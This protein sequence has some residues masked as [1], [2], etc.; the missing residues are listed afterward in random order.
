[1]Q[2]R[3]LMSDDCRMWYGTHGIPDTPAITM[4]HGFTGSHA[5]WTKLEE[6]L[7]KDSFFLI[8]PDL[9]GHGRSANLIDPEIMTL[10][11]ISDDLHRLLDSRGIKKTAL[12]GYSMGGRAALYFALKY[13][14]RIDCLIL[15]SAS[16]GIQDPWERE[17]R[18]A[19]DAVLAA[20]I[21]KFGIPWFVEKWEGMQLFATQ[22]EMDPEVRESV[23]KER[24]SQSAR[25]LA[26]SL[27]YA[28]SGAME[29]LWARLGDLRIPVLL[30]VGRRDEKF[31]TIGKEMQERMAENCVL[32]VVEDAGHAPHLE[33]PV[34]F[35]KIVKQF[36][37]EI[38]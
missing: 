8:A 19:V 25:G 32:K 15:E 2:Q 17:K 9:P 10:G 3:D 16:P 26:M 28:G 38:E 30:I 21:E 29:P 13:S 24:M 18:R 31:L 35:G 33:N 22:K 20:D 34:E 4:L 11:G 37:S 1:M 36:L 6:E 5:T 23:R 14:D 27:S 12:V 7:S